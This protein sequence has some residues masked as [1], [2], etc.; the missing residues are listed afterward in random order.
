VRSRD[1]VVPTS[2]G[3]GGILHKLVAAALLAG[4]V[5]VPVTPAHADDAV[6]P[7]RVMVLGD[8]VS[9][10]LSGDHTWRYFSAK[11]LQQT[12]ATVDFVG[13][14]VGTYSDDGWFAGTYAD[15]GFDQ[16]HASRYGL[17]MWETLFFPGSEITPSVETL[18]SYDPDVIV[19]A[20]GVNDLMVMNQT[21]EDLA[22]YV[23][24]FVGKARAVNPDVDIVVMSLPQVWIERVPAYNALLP[25]VAAGL[26]TPESRVVVTP[27]ADFT[28]GVETYDDA[29]PT[30]LG[31]RKIATSVSAGLEQ[32]GIGHEVLMPEPGTA[33]PPAPPPPVPAPIPSTPPAE[34]GLAP[35]VAPAPAVP[36]MAEPGAPRR[37]RAVREGRRTTVTWRRGRGATSYVVRC[38]RMVRSVEFR[39]AVLRGTATA[40]SV[41]SVNDVGVSDRI[42]VVVR[43][44]S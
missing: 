26:S 22:R 35:V 10:G 2:L 31:M 21:S 23:E 16:D 30:L 34:A 40:C 3:F 25:V 37:V 15:P 14:H 19:E 41:R 44:R 39:P 28:R 8:S 1:T 7:T 20:L 13:P 11:G 43:F 42:K 27:L 18:M 5:S 4:A 33:E 32:L 6:D 17:S 24:E 29:H 38:G 36:V 12:G 9:H